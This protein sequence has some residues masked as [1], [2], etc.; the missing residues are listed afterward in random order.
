MR[1]LVGNRE[2]GG[3]ARV[4]VAARDRIIPVPSSLTV[5]D[6]A[7]ADGAS[8][9]GLTVSNAIARAALAVPSDAV[10]VKLSGP[11]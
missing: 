2:F 3:V 6:P 8:F 4:D 7:M 1:R 5:A 11:L 9:T 10:K